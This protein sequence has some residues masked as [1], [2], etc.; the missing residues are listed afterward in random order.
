[1]LDGLYIN[2]MPIASHF[3]DWAADDSL[4]EA[5]WTYWSALRGERACPSRADL[6]PADIPKLLP[7]IGLIDVEP[8]PLRFR[9]RLIGTHMNEMFGED[10]TG[11][12]LDA[13]K[14]G[15]YA[16]F[17]HDLYAEAAL[18]RR[19]VYSESVFGYRD[20]RHLAIRRLVLPLAQSDDA[21]V[22]M[23]LF[24]N[25]FYPRRADTPDVP[26]TGAPYRAGNIVEI[27]TLARRQP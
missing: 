18:D 22:R 3:A 16:S 11:T 8:A 7:H 4:L 2:N 6:D 17:L 23:L 10:F 9:Y 5:V 13:A 20:R 25:T 14:G 27:H 19:P 24:S 15:N 1:M 12:Y 21:P 26:D